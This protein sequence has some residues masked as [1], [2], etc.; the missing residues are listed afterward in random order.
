MSEELEQQAQEEQT[1][2]EPVVPE[3]D[4]FPQ[5][6]WGKPISE[7]LNS[8]REAE[9]KIRETSERANQLEEQ[10][11]QLASQEQKPEETPV[12][13]EELGD[14]EFLTTAQVKKLMQEQQKQFE[15]KLQKTQEEAIQ[16]T[17]AQLE[18]RQF[19]KDH[20]DIFKDK[21]PEQIDKIIKTIASV[22]FTN[23]ATD[24]ESAYQAFKQT[25][26]EAG[27]KINE[28]EIGTRPIPSNLNGNVPAQESPDDEVERM[29][30]FHKKNSGSLGSFIKY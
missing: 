17:M 9:N 5:K 12:E 18:K 26:E 15:E 13:T 21:K 25:A 30:N 8:Y 29:I 14:F 19:L 3:S 10:L 1:L 22:G 24:L 16:T 23:G 20:A 11:N 4:E 2:E 28:G 7:V 6:F 27:L